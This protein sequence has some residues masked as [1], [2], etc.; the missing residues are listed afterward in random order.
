MDWFLYNRDP[1]HERFNKVVGLQ[2]KT[3]LKS[4]HR[5][6]YFPVSFAKFVKTGFL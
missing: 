2:P 6:K 1:R 3:L 4:R 5:H